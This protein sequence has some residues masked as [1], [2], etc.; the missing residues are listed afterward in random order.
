MNP[1][2]QVKSFLN[3]KVE[4]IYMD[5]SITALEN[6]IKKIKGFVGDFFE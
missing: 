1:L 2:N 4:Q 5:K 3:R 6:S